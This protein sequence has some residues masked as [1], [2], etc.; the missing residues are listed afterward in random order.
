MG[1]WEEGLCHDICGVLESG[2]RQVL[3]C[4]VL[5]RTGERIGPSVIDKDWWT[6][7]G[8]G[9]EMSWGVKYCLMLSIQ[10]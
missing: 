9:F 3:Q 1:W 5:I 6:Q 7:H 2:V 10:E 4:S 8:E